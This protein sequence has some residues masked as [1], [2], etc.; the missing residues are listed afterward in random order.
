MIKKIFSHS[1]VYGLA[2]QI[3]KIINILVYPIIT[4][5]LTETDFGVYGILIAATGALSALG[6]LGLIVTLS[7]S[8]YKS[9]SS[10]HWGWRQVYG[11]LTFWNIPFAFLMA[12]ILYLFI[13]DIAAENTLYIILLNVIPIVFFG[14]TATI[15]TLYFQ[16]KQK[17]LEIGIRSAGIGI[18]SVVLNILFI[19]HF[20][21]GYLGWFLAGGIS[22]VLLQFSYWLPLNL[23]YKLTPIYN[24]KWRYIKNQLKIGLPTIPHQYSSYL[25]NSS[26]R[27]VMNILNVTT[28]NIG[29]YNAAGNIALNGEIVGLAMG[30]A[31]TPIQLEFFK[32]GDEK[33]ARKMIFI[34]QIVFL[35]AS[36]TICIWM[37]EI[38]KLLIKND[39]LQTVYPLAIIMTMA[40]NY[41]PMYFGAVNR[42]FYI[43]ATKKL[44]YVTLTGGII[45]II[46]D[47]L[48]IPI[49]GYQISAFTTYIGLMYMGYSGFYM[50]EYRNAVKIKYYPYIWLILTCILTAAAYLVVELS[51]PI[52]GVVSSIAIT[53]GVIILIKLSK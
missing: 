40:Y 46:L 53:T 10:Y 12:G 25:L 22:Q 8:F 1:V 34:L 27:A 31:I 11:F 43:E 45:K 15:G 3:P 47:L 29:K 44:M 6:N 16:L 9:P 30:K 33:N 36:F 4:R 13:P 18:L 51:P 35:T 32:K 52:K 19:V 37:K 5:Y 26:D 14:P 24:F 20:K 17:P 28:A 48:L 2:P 38:F 41:K 21:L 23:K 39:T 49:I 42:L 7:N 50:K